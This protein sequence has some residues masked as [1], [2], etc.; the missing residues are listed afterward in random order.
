MEHLD[1]AAVA[2]ELVERVERQPVGQRVDQHRALVALAGPRELHEAE[3]RI[4]GPLAQELGVDGDVGQPA[5][6]AQK[7]GERVGVGDRGDGR[8]PCPDA[9]NGVNSELCK[10]TPQQHG[11]LLHNCRVEA[12]RGRYRRCRGG[13]GRVWQGRG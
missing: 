5:A 11:V 9:D 13:S 8:R 6:S 7:R 1:D 12:R 2:E 3:L 4:V 10:A